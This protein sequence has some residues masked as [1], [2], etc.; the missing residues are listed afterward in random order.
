MRDAGYMMSYR[1][2]EIW[3]LARQLTVDVHKMTVE[4]LPKFELYEQGSQIRRSMKSVK[5][6]T[7]EGYGRRRYKQEFIRFLTYAHASCD[8]TIDH[9]ETLFE[10]G[11]L[12]DKPVYED[13]RKRLD[14]LGEKLNRFIQGV[15]ASHRSASED[16]ADYLVNS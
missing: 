2:L 12:P 9:L 13:L 1:K 16:S 6:N 11:S 10:T 5:S 4:R 8:E 14:V 15:E 3:Q 7:V